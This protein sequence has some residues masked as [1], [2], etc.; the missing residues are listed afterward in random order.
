MK[1]LAPHILV[2]SILL[3]CAKAEETQLSKYL[4]TV[5]QNEWDELFITKSKTPISASSNSKIGTKP[6]QLLQPEVKKFKPSD[7]KLRGQFKFFK[8]WAFFSGELVNKKGEATTPDDCVSS[9]SVALF[10]KTI[11]GW[12]VVD[13]GI[14]ISDAF[15]I[16]WPSQYGAPVELFTSETK[17]K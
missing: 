3:C 7:L 14:G 12:K 16:V 10:L 1:F 11:D 13:H 6:L 17:N 8:N 2:S 9:D 4:S 5:E 15:F